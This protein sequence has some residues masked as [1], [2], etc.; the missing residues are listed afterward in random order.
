M[1]QSL[2]S[3]IVDIQLSRGIFPQN[4]GFID[5]APF[6]I[7]SM[8]NTTIIASKRCKSPTTKLLISSYV[9]A[10]DNLSVS[11]LVARLVASKL[12][13]ASR[14]VISFTETN[15]TKKGSLQIVGRIY[16]PGIEISR[17][18]A[19]VIHKVNLRYVVALENLSV[20][21]LVARVVVSKLNK[22]SREVTLSIETTLT[23]KKGS[24]QIVGRIK[25]PG[26]EISRSNAPGIHKVTRKSAYKLS[27]SVVA[28]KS[29]KHTTCF[30][31]VV[32]EGQGIVTK[33]L[34]YVTTK[35]LVLKDESNNIKG[36]SSSST[37]TNFLLRK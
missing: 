24:L 18:K 30:D 35:S 14:E 34:T 37:N 15:L 21:A 9:V 8:L 19:L 16:K 22:A 13:K 3:N 2:L 32:I 26:I 27:T 12:D 31:Y 7:P 28:S 23:Y 6:S 4:K 11:A 25:K 5:Y 1:S 17:S 20:S 29:K 33:Y 10:L 36:C